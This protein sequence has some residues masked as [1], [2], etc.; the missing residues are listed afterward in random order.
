[1][2]TA[3]ARKLPRVDED[4][5]LAAFRRAPTDDT[6]ETEDERRAVEA[7]KAMAASMAHHEVATIIARTRGE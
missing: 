5:V 4:P 7:A 6:V 1:M 2:S 3:A